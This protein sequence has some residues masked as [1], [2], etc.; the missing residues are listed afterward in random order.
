[1]SGN[2]TRGWISVVLW[3]GV[4]NGAAPAV[5]PS[6]RA[7]PWTDV[8]DFGAR[9]DGQADDTAIRARPGVNL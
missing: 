6:S 4:T 7:L 3:L 9:G 2:R 8:L 5:A 1:M